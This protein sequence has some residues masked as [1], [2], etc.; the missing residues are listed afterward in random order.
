M[1]DQEPRLD[2]NQNPTEVKIQKP[3]ETVAMPNSELTKPAEGQTTDQEQAITQSV[4]QYLE[5]HWAEFLAKANPEQLI[6]EII[7][8]RGSLNSNQ[9]FKF[10]ST[11]SEQEIAENLSGICQENMFFSLI[12][13]D[14]TGY[15]LRS[16]YQ[17][18][19]DLLEFL[20]Q[21]YFDFINETIIT[22]QRILSFKKGDLGIWDRDYVELYLQLRYAQQERK[23]QDEPIF[24]A[25]IDMDKLSVINNTHGHETG[26][27]VIKALADSMRT[28]FT[29][30]SDMVGR[31]GGDEF[32]AV[33]P[34]K[35][36]DKNDEYDKLVNDTK[37]LFSELKATFHDLLEERG[38]PITTIS[39]GGYGFERLQ[40]TNE[41][42]QL[43]KELLLKPDEL[44]YKGK[45]TRDATV[46]DLSALKLAAFRTLVDDQTNTLSG[47]N[48]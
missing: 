43:L 25:F 36:P 42:A 40:K 46:V 17:T 11:G 39:I 38:L 14:L 16:E 45:E 18:G 20:D 15:L 22:I 3:A 41:A 34:V 21:H 26:D 33:L 31:W 37:Q 2:S 24:I 29:R 1:S 4:E 35:L 5:D 13:E 48:S 19:Q 30:A 12:V 47:E 9:A 32:I 27:Q 10:F 28:V 44:L 7:R 6:A 23:E 8:R